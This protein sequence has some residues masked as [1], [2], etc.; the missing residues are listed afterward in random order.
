MLSK[1][2]LYL[3][4][5]F[6]VGAG[7]N[8]FLSPNFYLKMMPPWLPWPSQLHL[9]AGAAEMLLGMALIPEK[10][11]RL[12][13][14]GLVAL[15]IAVFPAN[16]YLAMNP[17]LMPNVSPSGHWLRLPFQLLFLA[18]AYSCTKPISRMGTSQ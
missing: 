15:L 7:L 3:Q 4:A 17:E 5:V 9:L 13:A 10:T 2:L 8:H 14:W 6:Y 1:I 16:I 11:R 18:W 12:A